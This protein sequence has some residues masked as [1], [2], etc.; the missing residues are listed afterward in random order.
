MPVWWLVVTSLSSHQFTDALFLC[1][2]SRSH[3]DAE[4]FLF[5]ASST[6]SSQINVN[7]HRSSYLVL[8]LP[9]LRELLWSVKLHLYFHWCTVLFPFFSSLRGTILDGTLAAV[10]F[11]FFRVVIFQFFLWA[12]HCSRWLDEDDD[13]IRGWTNDTWQVARWQ[14][15]KCKVQCETTV[16]ENNSIVT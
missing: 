1:I 14:G 9:S 4:R 12:I 13:E 16:K 5:F 7:V 15:K 10:A 8:C 6:P 11:T 2:G 3:K